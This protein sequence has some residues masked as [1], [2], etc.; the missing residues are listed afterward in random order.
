MSVCNDI[1]SFHF[2]KEK[3]NFTKRAMSVGEFEVAGYKF[4]LTD[5]L[6]TV[7]KEGSPSFTLRIGVMR[8]G[9]NNDVEGLVIQVHSTIHATI[10]TDRQFMRL[11]YYEPNFNSDGNG[12]IEVSVKS[13]IPGD[14]PSWSTLMNGIPRQV[15]VTGIAILNGDDDVEQYRIRRNNEGEVIVNAEDPNFSNEN[16]PVPRG[17]NNGN[18]PSGNNKGGRRRRRQTRKPRRH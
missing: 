12:Q 1:S 10:E 5:T 3:I 18:N 2:Q 16:V 17:N 14:I 13:D 15:I 11:I 4:R 6:F 9:N 8:I 7:R